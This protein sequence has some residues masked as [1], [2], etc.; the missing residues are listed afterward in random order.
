MNVNKEEEYHATLHCGV[1]FDCVVGEW[2]S[3]LIA[4]VFISWSMR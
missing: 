3:V 1:E 2:V 4:P